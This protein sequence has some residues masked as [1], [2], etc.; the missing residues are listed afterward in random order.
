MFEDIN[1]RPIYTKLTDYVTYI[2]PSI[3]SDKT[4]IGRLHSDQF[5]S[6]LVVR[7]RPEFTVYHLESEWELHETLQGS[8]NSVRKLLDAVK[9]S[10][11][12]GKFSGKAGKVKTLNESFLV[13]E[14][15]KERKP[16]VIKQENDYRVGDVSVQSRYGLA[17]YAEATLSSENWDGPIELCKESGD[18]FFSIISDKSG[19][20][21][22]GS[23]TDPSQLA[24]MLSI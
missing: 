23:F 9:L 3:R 1:A 2:E 24:K 10:N 13:H 19:K 15:Q 8:F 5:P 22:S 17:G 11:E 21:A 7:Q 14:R 6:D 18:H 16:P 4:Q 12:S 20:G